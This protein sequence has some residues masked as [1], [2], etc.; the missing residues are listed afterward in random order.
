[1]N[2]P[3]SR[4]ISLFISLV[5]GGFSLCGGFFPVYA[6][7]THQTATKASSCLQPP[8]NTDLTQLSDAELKSYGLPIHATINTNPQVWAN[9]LAHVQ[10]RTCGSTPGQS[11]RTHSIQPH[12]AK[13]GEHGSGNWSGNAANAARGTYRY[14]DVTFN[15]PFISFSNKSA[16][17]AIWAG[18]G[19][20]PA[21]S[22]NAVLVQAGVNTSIVNGKQYNMSF[23]EVYPGF[24]EQNLPLSRLNAGDQVYAYAESN[25]NGSGYNYF[26]IDNETIGSYNSIYNYGYFS[27]SAI[28]ECILERPSVNNT[29]TPLLQVNP[30]AGSLSN[31]ETLNYCEVGTNG[32]GNGVGNVTHF[33]YTMYG[34]S[35]NVLAY[36]GPIYGNGYD[37]LIYWRASS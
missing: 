24:A 19:G 9:T 30:N 4:V 17:V 11:K 31:T 29:P 25:L 6:A 32:G 21:I 28:G 36:P 37:F 13:A 5:I 20:D 33:Y 1:M 10:H 8:R 22:G 2:K 3:L 34:N 16:Q 12:K 26:F 14:A 23:Y 35:G 27:D 15:V 7:S 18:V